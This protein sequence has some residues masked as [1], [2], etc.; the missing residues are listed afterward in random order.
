MAYDDKV[1]ERALKRYEYYGGNLK[2]VSQ[3]EGMPSRPTLRK[4]RDE[5][6]P[7]EITGGRDWDKFLKD[8]REKALTQRRMEIA[9]R[10]EENADD[11]V[12]T[13]K[14]HI[15]EML[16]VI[17]DKFLTGEV[18]VKGSDYVKL[19]EK[20]MMLE[21]MDAEKLSFMRW[22]VEEIFAIVVDEFRDEP[23]RIHRV[24]SEISRLLKDEMEKLNLPQNASKSVDV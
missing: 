16:E 21:N 17:H 20:A 22:F 3:D 8:K 13:S 19:L 7:H 5:G 10:A 14:K 12:G 18:D 15:S 4:M 6:R 23:G 1:A 9:Q 2:K 24:K 11:I